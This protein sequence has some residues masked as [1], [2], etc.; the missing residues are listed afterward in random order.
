[1]EMNGFTSTKEAFGEVFSSDIP[2][3][4]WTYLIDRLAPG[5][6]TSWAS[7]HLKLNYIARCWRISSIPL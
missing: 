6:W 4:N 2:F 1:M 5:G 7:E 3:C